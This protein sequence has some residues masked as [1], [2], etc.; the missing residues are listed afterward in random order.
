MQPPWRNTRH[1]PAPATWNIEAEA[2]GFQPDV[3]EKVAHLLACWKLS[4]PFVVYGA[5]N[6]RDWR[7]VSVADVAFDEAELSSQLLPALQFGD[8]PSVEA[9]SYGDRLVDKCRK[10]LS[11]LLPRQ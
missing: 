3:R 7:T 6:Q 8:L 11:V 2:T 5:M 4:P 9:T 10:A 1:T